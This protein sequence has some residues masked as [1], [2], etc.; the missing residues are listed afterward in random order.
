MS[1]RK[2]ARKIRADSGKSFPKSSGKVLARG[3]YGYN[4]VIAETLRT[5]F[6]GNGAAVKTVMRFTGAGERTVKNWLE[7]KN[8]PNGENLIELVRHS[9]EIF[10]ALLIMS[11][12]DDV[13]V[14]WTLVNARDKI[15][16]ML[17][18]I[19]QLLSHDITENGTN[20]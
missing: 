14:A 17:E 15:V 11:G 19:D 2:T 6:G 16:E 1:F 4:A 7:G 3:D 20:D 5:T 9:D 18:A 12:R 10:E 8:G 13:L